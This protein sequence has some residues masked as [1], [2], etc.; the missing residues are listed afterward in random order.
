MTLVLYSF[1]T[2]ERS[3]RAI[4]RH[5][6]QDVAFRVITSNVVPDHATIARFL[7][8]HERAL[9]DL[10]GAVLALCARAG[11]VDSR[12]VAVDGTKISGSAHRDRSLSYEEIAREIIAE[13]IATDEAEDEQ[14]GDAR[15]DELPEALRTPEGRREWLRRELVRDRDLP[16]AED[17]ADAFDA[18]LIVDRVQGREGWAREARRQLEAERW[19]TATPIARSRA[20]RLRDGAARLEDDQAA[21]VRGM[22]AYEAYRARG[23]MKDGR[24]FGRPPNP[25]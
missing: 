7:G 16:P 8:R 13:T 1:A 2:G 24:R 18:Q 20:Q 3:S 15:G 23:R 4:E 17:E 22:R 10:F 12:V 25:W 6:R 11:I 9:C 14:F 5:C 21:R 19:Q